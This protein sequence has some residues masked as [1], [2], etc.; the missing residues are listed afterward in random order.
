MSEAIDTKARDMAA[1][2]KTTAE[3]ALTKIEGHE[4][5][6]A[7]RWIQVQAAISRIFKRQWAAMTA[8]MVGMAVIIAKQFGLLP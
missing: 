8:I 4:V 3:V 1:E 7:E 2:A 6:C 5:I